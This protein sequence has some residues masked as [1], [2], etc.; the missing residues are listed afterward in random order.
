MPSLAFRMH[1]E[2]GTLVSPGGSNPT[3]PTDAP[4]L[5]PDSNPMG[6]RLEKSS[7]TFMRVLSLCLRIRQASYQEKQLQTK[8][9]VATNGSSQRQCTGED[10]LHTAESLCDITAHSVDSCALVNL[11]DYCFVPRMKRP[12]PSQLQSKG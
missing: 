9:Q 12:H 7:L 1:T 10:N 4:C 3:T 8:S 2:L 6:A 5:H 11:Y